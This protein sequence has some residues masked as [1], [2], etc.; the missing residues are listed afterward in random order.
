MT[1]NQLRTPTQLATATP[2]WRALPVLVA[3]VYLV[4]LDFFIVN[5]ALPSIQAD[6]GADA[7]ALEWVVS[8]YGL[9]L[10]ATLLTAGRI[11][12][13]IGRRRMYG[14]G[15]AG[16]VVASLVCALARTP[17]ELV[18][19]RLVQGVGAGIVIPSMLSLLGVHFPGPH[20]ARA[21]GVYGLAMGV[22]AA[23]G[24]LIGGVLIQAGLGWRAIFAINIPVGVAIL[25]LAPVLVPESKAAAPRPIDW[26][27]MLL[28]TSSVTAL[29]LPL[30]QGRSQGWPTWTWAVLGLSGVLLATTVAQQR[31]LGRRGGAPLF[32]AELLT[33]PTFR[34]GLGAQLVFWC[35]QASF[36]LCLSLYLQQGRGLS[37]LDSG[38]LFT[39]LALAYLSTSLRAPALIGR[40]GRSVVIA[41]ALVT[42]AG[43]AAFGVAVVGFDG[44]S[45]LM[46]GPGLLLVGAG[47]GLCITPLTM[48]VLAHARPSQAG[49]VSGALSTAQQIG[50]T[51]GVALIGV[52]FFGAV[53][54]GVP[55]AFALAL[56]PLAMVSVLV[57]VVARRLPPS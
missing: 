13:V 3:G 6:L 10:G 11:G 22:A 53:G 7:A 28:L 46:L 50:N 14:V 52:V 29:I 57:A 25:V 48:A 4:V 54:E 24:Q 9:A 44:W 39:V 26:V 17:G 15:V 40:F 19:G 38:L 31:R 43:Y 47:Q 55:H 32:P 18:A 51:V 49:T 2:P 12:D 20:R 5:V 56:V 1:Q 23:S 8:G 41:G 27:G 42:L 45:V 37:P 33:S 21:I 30:I 16:F 36:Y 34:S 35:G